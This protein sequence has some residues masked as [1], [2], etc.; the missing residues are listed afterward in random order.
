MHNAY[1]LTNK[2]SLAE[3]HKCA[4][5]TLMHWTD[6]LHRSLVSASDLITRLDVDARLLAEAN[7]NLD[8]ALFPL[9]ARIALTQD[10]NVAA[11]ANLLSKDH[12]SVS[13]QI[14]KLE[15]LGLITRTGNPEDQRSR[16]LTLTPE[17]LVMMEK[18]STVRRK[19][20]VKHFE[21]WDEKDRD[22]LVNLLNK[23]FDKQY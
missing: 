16:Q 18:I 23:M 8:R 22:L 10:T 12:S 20:M 11:L 4:L 5:C 1:K 15:K 14:L 19:W 6:L 17:A 13:R 7:V 2:F 3:Q 9:L 21:E